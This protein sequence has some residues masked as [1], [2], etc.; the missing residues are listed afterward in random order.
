MHGEPCLCSHCVSRSVQGANRCGA[1]SKRVMEVDLAALHRAGPRGA[2]RR[3]RHGR[4]KPVKIDITKPV[5]AERTVLNRRAAVAGA[6]LRQDRRA[7]LRPVWDGG[8]GGA[9][10]LALVDL[11]A[12]DV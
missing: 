3:R 6:A 1:P 4:L 2:D 9:P 10:A 12:P 5:H 7:R 8:K 11:V